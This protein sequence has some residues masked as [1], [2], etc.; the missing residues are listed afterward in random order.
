MAERLL[1]VVRIELQAALPAQPAQH[2]GFVLPSF[3]GVAKFRVPAG[4]S[5]KQQGVLH[6]HAK[7]NRNRSLIRQTATSALGGRSVVKRYGAA[8]ETAH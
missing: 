8:E 3:E 6:G 7:D 1:K 5:K 4:G 2:P